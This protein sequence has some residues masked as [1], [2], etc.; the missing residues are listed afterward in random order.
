MEK[1]SGLVQPSAPTV[2]CNKAVFSLKIPEFFEAEDLGVAPART[3][4]RCRGCRDCSYRNSMV[5][6]DKELVVQRMEDQLCYDERTQK[7]TVSYPWNQDVFKLSD[8]LQQAIRM[9]CSVERRLLRDPLLMSAYNE[10]FM[11]FVNRGAISR[12]TQQEMDSYQGPVSYVTHLPVLKPDSTTT[13]LRIVTNTSF[14]NQNAKL[15]PNNCMDEGPNALSPLL[16]V[17]IGFRLEEV[18][19]VYDLT[20]AYQSIQTGEVERHVRRIA[21]RFGDTL[22]DWQIFGYDVVTFGDQVAGLA[23]ELV[24][25]LAAELGRS[26]DPEASH[27]L[28]TKTYVDDGAGGGSRAQVERY[29]GKEV[30]GIYDGTLAQIL[31]LVNLR[32]KVMV[33]SGDTD[34]NKL[35]ILGDKVLGHVWLA[36]E[37]KLVFRVAVNLT[38]AKLKKGGHVGAE[39]LSEVDIPR[40]INIKLTK[41][42]LLGLVNSQYDPMGL[43]CPLL[44]ILKIHLRELFGPGVSLSWDEP[45][46]PENHDDWVTILTMFLKMGDIV[47]D[48]AVRPEGAIG[49]PELIGFSD[50]SL[51]AYGC[52]VYIRWKKAKSLIAD[53]DRYF[54][55][56]VCGKARVTSAKGTTA[57]RSEVSGYLILT[58]LLKT[59]VNAMDVKP[60]QITLAMDSQCT[61]SAVEK[62]GGVLAPYFASRVSEASANLTEIGEVVPVNP[63]MHVPGILNP[64]DIP[65]RPT[66]TPKEVMEGS[67]WQCGP[68]YLALPKEKWPFSR[69]FRD[70][71]PAE[72]LRRPRAAFGKTHVEAWTSPLGIRLTTIVEGVMERSNSYAKTVHVTARLLK[73]LF[74]KSRSRIE[75]PLTVDDILV[76]RKVQFMVS[77]GPTIQAV[78]KGDLEPLRPFME[79]GIVYI[80]GRCGDSLMKLLG[81]S[82]LPVLVRQSRLA[83]LIMQEAHHEDH[84]SSASNVLARSRQRAWIIRGRFLAKL[85]CKSCPLCKLNRRKM[86][87]QLMADIPAHQ[88][89]PCPPFS[90]VSLDFAGPYMAKAMGNS[91]TQ[92]KVWGLVVVCQNTRAIKMYATAG[93]GTDDFLTA[94]TRFT[95]NH[96]N[97][98]LVVSD[99]GSQLVKAGKVID[100]IDLSKLDW[101]KITEGAAKNGTKWKIVEPGCQWRNGLAESAVKLIKSTLALTLASQ[102]TLNFAELD[103]LF[104]SVANVVNQRPIAV[105]SYTEDDIHAICP[106]DLLLQRS[107]NTVPGVQ[108][109]EEETVTRRQ[110]VMKEIEDTWWRQW[111][112]QALPHL[113]PFKKWRQEFRS[114]KKGD[115]VLIL[116]DRNIGKGDY[117]LARVQEVYPDV[118]GVVR[119]VRV[120]FRRRNAR[121]ASLPYVVKP[122]EE[123]DLGVQ[124]LAVISPIEE[125]TGNESCQGDKAKEIVG[126]SSQGVDGDRENERE[127]N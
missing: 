114:V 99:S 80:K 27:Q 24:K 104:S 19:L 77:M 29:M 13:P 122:L 125:Q 62:S 54:V 21:W 89:Y 103:T 55:K 94:F 123:M 75:E 121:E 39:D 98:L 68:S 12:I 41:R 31:S 64:A 7:V 120:G 45:I 106:N 126:Q 92:I 109:A 14:V 43:I 11:K 37:D 119:T 23:L 91:R 17:L 6:K 8:N 116:Y 44:I 67:L 84:R 36:T 1:G 117:R 65:T 102:R 25:G 69:E 66:T 32:P 30:D 83:Y 111:I 70:T 16:E 18:A 79:K 9:Q 115:I 4:K 86:T 42:I 81:I 63:I 53:P 38:P 35:K 113:V 124:R 87:Q 105:Q 101:K 74:D 57:P 58:R 90:Y 71:L 100:Q 78:D 15:S 95:A 3:C 34:E 28:K 47:L 22:A 107:K 20:K 2:L 82:C 97:P 108:Y 33:A 40:L 50:G 51:V 59:V 61:I 10:E 73:C 72:E 5:S 96:G 85:V 110:Q 52:A 56:L 112:V 127:D 118:H 26:I 49:P 60:D 46:P 88:L 76:A 48:R 93:Y